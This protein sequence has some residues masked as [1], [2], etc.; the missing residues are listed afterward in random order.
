MVVARVT[1]L[2]DRARSVRD[3]PASQLL[4]IPNYRRLV[5]GFALGFAAFN[6]RL[7]AQSWLVLD[8]TDSTL[9]VGVV[10]GASTVTVM[11]FSL[12]AG[13]LA[14]VTSRQVV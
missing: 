1:A 7:M 14:E 2:G 10:A 13:A 9:W 4:A 3:A 8:I 12:V 11:A 6:I 5:A